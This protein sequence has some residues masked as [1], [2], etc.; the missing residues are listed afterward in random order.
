MPMP[1]LPPARIPLVTLVLS[2]ACHQKLP[3]PTSSGTDDSTAS[4]EPTGTDPTGSPDYPAVACGDLVC[5]PGNICVFQIEMCTLIPV[6]AQCLPDLTETG[7]GTGTTE[8]S[9]TS[10]I[11]PEPEYCWSFPDTYRCEPIPRGCEPGPE[12]ADCIEHHFDCNR[13][14]DGRRCR[15]RFRRR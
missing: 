5:E 11:D 6:P 15:R 14:N 1:V 12:F 2:V 9:E 13:Q 3:G 7:L 8:S 4:G 10:S